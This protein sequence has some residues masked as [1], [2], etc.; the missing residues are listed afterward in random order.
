MHENKKWVF[1]PNKLVREGVFY[2]QSRSNES[3][4]KVVAF[5][6][7]GPLRGTS[8]VSYADLSRPKKKNG[9]P[10]QLPRLS[11]FE[12]FDDIMAG[13]KVYVGRYLLDIDP[14]ATPKP[15]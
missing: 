5:S 13:R 15:L 14:S 12:H 10:L 6:Q 4:W 8:A 3:L 2:F 11:D 7:G 1:R 9:K